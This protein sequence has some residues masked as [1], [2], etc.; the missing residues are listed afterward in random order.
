MKDEKNSVATICE[1]NHSVLLIMDWI[2][3]NIKGNSIDIA[4]II[5]CN[6]VDQRI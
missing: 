3:N 1:D 6:V 2:K 4:S 5:T